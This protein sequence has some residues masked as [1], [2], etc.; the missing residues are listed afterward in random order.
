MTGTIE[1]NVQDFYGKLL[2]CEANSG[3]MRW[4][5]ICE[6]MVSIYEIKFLTPQKKIGSRELW[7]LLFEPDQK[8][9]IKKNKLIQVFKDENYRDFFMNILYKGLEDPMEW[10]EWVTKFRY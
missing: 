5:A 3:K 2:H 7:A 6:D 8:Q 9:Q 10:D 4:N 1:Q